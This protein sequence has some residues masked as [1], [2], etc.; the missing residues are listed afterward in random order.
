MLNPLLLIYTLVY[1]DKDYVSICFQLIQID[2][3]EVAILLMNYL[4]EYVFQIK[5]KT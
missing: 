1:T 5:Q 2:V 3:L 4:I